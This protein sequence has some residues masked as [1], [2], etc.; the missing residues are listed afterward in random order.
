MTPPGMTDPAGAAVA[1][2]THDGYPSPLQARRLAEFAP[3]VVEALD[4]GA[5]ELVAEGVAAETRRGYAGD[6]GSYG[7]WCAER[8]L[9]PI[10]A[11]AERLVNYVAHLAGEGKA[12]SSIE[13]AVAAILSAHRLAGAARLDTKAAR[14]AI[15]ALRRRRAESG[16][17]PRKATA[18]SVAELRRLVATTTDA[19]TVIGARDRAMILLGFAGMFR[20]S[21]IAGLSAADVEESPEGLVVTVRRSKTDQAGEGA[22]VAILAGAFADTCPVRPWPPGGRWQASWTGRCSAGL[23]DMAACSAP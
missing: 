20:R 7:A 19:A 18:A 13:R 11:T 2:A 9:A 5:A 22:V 21:E 23:I 15:K 3:Q 10:P 14:T 16:A 1:R 17:G 8:G 12:P 4:A 6:L